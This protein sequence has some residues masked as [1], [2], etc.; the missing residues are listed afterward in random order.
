MV[1]VVR[2]NGD[3]VAGKGAGGQALGLVHGIGEHFRRHVARS[4]HPEGPQIAHQRNQLGIAD[5]GHGPTHDGQ[6]RAEELLAAAP[7]LVEPF[8]GFHDFMGRHGSPP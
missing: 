8:G 4:Q 1:Q 6:F 7:D 2:G 3:D 5:P